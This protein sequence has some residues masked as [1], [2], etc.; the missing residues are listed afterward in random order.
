MTRSLF[1]RSGLERL[2]GLAGRNTLVVLDF[3]GTLS[4][5]VVDRDRARLRAPTRRLL[6]KVAQ[7]YPVAVLSGRARADVATRLAGLPLAAIIGNHGA[8][9][10]E[11]TRE[12]PRVRRWQ[13]KLERSLG[14]LP[15]VEIEDKGQSL[16]IH[17]RRA[18]RR[19]QAHRAIARAVDALPGARRVDG[20]AVVNVVAQGA[21][22]KGTAILRLS[23]ALGADAV[24][25]VGDDVT[26]EDA[27]ALAGP[28]FCGVRVGGSRRT[29]ASHHLRDQSEIDRLLAELIRL[30]TPR[31]RSRVPPA[32]AAL[33][34]L[35]L[36]SCDPAPPGP[37][38]IEPSKPVPA[39]TASARTKPDPPARAPFNVLLLLIDSWRAD[40]SWTGYPRQTTPRI[41]AFRR[42]HCVAYANGYSL[43]SY[44]AKSVVPALV[45][46]YPSAMRRDGYFFTRYPDRH[47]LFISE[48]AQ[49][50]GHRTLSAQ[51]HGYFLPTFLT[52]QGFDVHRTLPGGVDLKEVAS[53]SGEPLTRL[54]KEVLG[55]PANSNQARGKR[56]FL[57]AHYMDP[58]H[59]YEQHKGVERFGRHPRDLYDHEVAYTD[60]WVGELLDFAQKKPWWPHTAVIISSDH[61]EGFG[62]RK[63]NRHGHEL[64]ESIVRVPWLVCVPGAKPRIVSDVRRSHIDLAPTIADLMGLSATPP[65]RGKS[66]VPELLGSEPA[67]PRRVVVDQPRSDLMDRRRAVIDGDWKIV[68]FGDDRAFSLFDLASDPWEETDL[69]AARPEELARMKR[70]YDEESKKIPLVEVERGPDLKGAPRGRRW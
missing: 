44:T 15:G 35:S 19:T 40:V 25:F 36:A 2:S 5:I 14:S 43:S 29:A 46:E 28:D 32:L 61:G 63:H 9:D 11:H 24:L 45:G 10:G 59:T 38:A 18:P 64:W 1:A 55:A 33:A 67:L 13:A 8:E 56:F 42:E 30:R 6:A 58:H 12:S 54:A 70:V 65:F 69:A 52:H 49:A 20:H 48:R 50:A 21:P 62:E 39:V 31:L 47:N 34:A 22:H 57:F 7:L 60:R 4:P 17:Y 53:V 23:K 16:S 26:D 37:I 27:F 3:D 66:L 41:D 51:A 68:A